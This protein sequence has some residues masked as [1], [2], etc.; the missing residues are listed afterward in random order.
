MVVNTDSSTVYSVWLKIFTDSPGVVADRI[1]ISG[2][3][4]PSAPIVTAPPIFGLAEAQMS[5]DGVGQLGVD[6][7]GRESIVLRLYRLGPRQERE[8]EVT[9]SATVDTKAKAS[10]IGYQNAPDP[11]TRGADGATGLAFSL[12]ETFRTR[13]PIFL[14]NSLKMLKR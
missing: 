14:H 8:F 9:T 6:A 11:H 7:G 4:D 5:L 3:T 2:Q 12:P 10:I 13:G 1:N